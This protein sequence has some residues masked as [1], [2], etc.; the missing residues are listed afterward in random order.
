MNSGPFLVG[1]K[2]FYIK[3]CIPNF[4]PKKEE[5]ENVLVWVRLYKLPRKYWDI[6][7]L[8]M[9][10]NKLGVFL[11]AD[12]ALEVNEFNMYARICIQWQSIHPL[13]KYVELKSIE[14]VWR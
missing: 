10:G 11:K 4:D 1:A 12:E 2:G 6:E 5:I 8:K 7:T 14:G 13:P 3:D 9:I